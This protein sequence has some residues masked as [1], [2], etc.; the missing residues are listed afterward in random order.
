MAVVR[1]TNTTP[2]GPV[3]SCDWIREEGGLIREIRSYY[4]ATLVK[5]TLDTDSY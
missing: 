5:A 1:F 3:D 4:D 2:N